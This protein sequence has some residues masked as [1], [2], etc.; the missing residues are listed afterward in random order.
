MY[1]QLSW[2][3]KVLFWVVTALIWASLFT[4]LII[5]SG[6]LFPFQTGKGIAYRALI[7]LA[8]FFYLWLILIEP[9]ARPKL[10][11]VMWAVLAFAAGL[12]ITTLF[13]VNVYRSFWGDIERMEGFFGIIHGVL[14]FVIAYGLFRSKEDWLNF[15]KVSLLASFFLAMYALAQVY[16]IFR[17]L[18]VFE[19][20]EYQP[21]STLGNPA[22]VSTY[23]IFQIFFASFILIWERNRWWQLYGAAMFVMNFIL[24]AHQEGIE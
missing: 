7:E 14:L 3:G 18:H 1:K 8:G 11:K 13:S 2:G 19:A 24:F 17:F 6:A 10:S 20:R 12:V 15:F 4:P 16:P 22:F 21:G 23:A 5:S 9:R